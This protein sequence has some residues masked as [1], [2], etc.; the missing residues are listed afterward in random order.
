MAGEGPF[1]GNALKCLA[2]AAA[3]TDPI[4]GS[5][6]KEFDFVW[7]VVLQR[8]HVGPPQTK[9]GACDG[10]IPLH[11]LS[12]DNNVRVVYFLRCFIEHIS[13]AKVPQTPGSFMPVASFPPAYLAF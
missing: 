4:L 3:Y 9:T 2:E 5:D 6:F 10:E 8:T 1:T 7:D 13:S 11:R 12:L